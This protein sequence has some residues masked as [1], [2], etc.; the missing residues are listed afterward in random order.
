MS[1]DRTQPASKHRRQMARERGQAAHSPELTAAVGW[2]VAVVALGVWGEDLT[3]SLIALVRSPLEGG[4]TITTNPADAVWRIRTAA[5]TASAPLAMILGGF[6]FGALAAHQ[7]QVRGLWAPSLLAP[8]VSRL[9]R[10]GRG[11]GLSAQFERS[12]WAIVKALILVF[13]AVWGIRSQWGALM[14]LGGLEPGPAA[15]AALEAILAPARLLAVLLLVVGLVDFA[16]R[17]A[18][19]EAM[20]RTTPQEQRED[21]K[22]IEGD[23]AARASRRRLAQSWLDPTPDLLA[24]ASLVLLGDACLAVVL[25]GG[26]PP[27]K[28][29]IRLVARGASGVSIRKAA[30]RAKVPRLEARLLAQTL[31]ALPRESSAKAAVRDPLILSQLRSVWPVN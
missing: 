10:P 3:A 5:L 24:G 23:P 16:L 11:G 13:A 22:M 19:F 6:L 4:A 20:L 21:R 26:P 8:D 28:V 29:S 7:A 17:F 30:P 18:R 14:N 27:R 15:S 2:L 31:A 1:E 9:W 25:G 12:A